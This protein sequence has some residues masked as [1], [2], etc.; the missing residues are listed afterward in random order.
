M[1]ERREQQLA[2]MQPLT[3]NWN[4]LT[5]AQ[6]VRARHE[7]HDIS[8]IPNDE[9]TASWVDVRELITEHTALVEQRDRLV[10]VL[11]KVRE[12]CNYRM[13]EDMG[14]ALLPLVTEIDAAL[15]DE[16]Q[17]KGGSGGEG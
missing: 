17:A 13:Y 12:A 15:A 3:R 6:Q 5:R 11:R 9:Y 8:D 16:P 10:T 2:E 7:V 14:A 4:E 1:I